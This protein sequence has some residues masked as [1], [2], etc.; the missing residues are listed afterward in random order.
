MA[1]LKGKLDNK[2]VV[3]KCKA[4]LKDLEKGTSLDVLRQCHVTD[5]F[6]YGLFF[7]NFV[8]YLWTIICYVKNIVEDIVYQMI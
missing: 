7:G 6:C 8:N 2:I 3:E 5:F 1:P 4:L